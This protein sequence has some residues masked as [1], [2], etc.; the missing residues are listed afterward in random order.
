MHFADLPLLP[1]LHDSLT[2]LQL[3]T[4]TDVQEQ[5]L[6]LLLE[7]KS[8]VAIAET[9]SGKTLAY[10]LP[11]LDRLKRME[12]DGNPVTTGSE[13]R[14]LVIVP[15]R[16]LGEQ[17]AGVFKSMTHTTRL[18]VRT[19]LGGQKMK[20]NRESVAGAFEVLVATPGRLERIVE[21]GE[22]SLAAMRVLVLDEADQLLDLGF[23]PTVM[24]LVRGVPSQCQLALFS[25][26]MSPAVEELVGR[27]FHDA[28]RVTTAGRGKVVASLKTRH[29]PVPDGRRAEALRAVLAEPVEGSTMLFANTREQ[30]EALATWLREEGR[31]CVVH[32]GEMDP[33]ER[34]KNLRAFREGGVDLFLTTDMGS[35]GLD[36]DHV[37]RVIN[38]HLP[39]Q[40][41]NYLHR[42]GRTARAQ[43]PGLVVN[44]VT[45]RDAP[46]LAQLGDGTKAPT[47][48]P[49]PG[50]VVVTAQ[51]PLGREGAGRPLPQ[52]PP[53]HGASRPGARE[54]AP[55]SFQRPDDARTAR[56][57]DAP[58]SFQRPNDA[59]RS[60]QRPS[61][62]PRG[63]QRPSDAPRSFQ[64]TDDAPRSFQRPSDAPRSFQRTDDAPRSFQRADDAR[65]ARRDDTPRSFQR[66]DD[67]RPPRRDDAPRSFQRPDDA[68][69]SFQRPSDA[70]RGFQRPN[71]TRPERRDEAPRSFQRPD[72][73]PRSFQRPDDARPP[74]RDDAPRSFQR[75][76]DARPP[77]R[78]D[79]P[80]SFQRPGNGPR[81]PGRGGRGGNGRGQR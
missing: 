5:A 71:D 74:R 60:F 72:D 73:A 58:R 36:I 3:D 53:P 49:A 10:V 33:I 50:S 17:V 25:A 78:D 80:R 27:A 34:R 59:P 68:A 81:G 67:A 47:R 62:A 21:S 16:E 12:D 29:V 19:V 56:R 45:P 54:D 15:T 52:R 42:V 39:R 40:L 11:V 38:V 70:P 48:F 30:C 14:A 2:A 66:P 69:R 7:R 8:V 26:T 35:R 64:R 51:T 1:S 46:L 57:D 31:T 65:P 41:E 22:L 20:M 55:R 43:R 79:A 18:R 61:D 28:T 24:A 75:P 4:L 37:A 32:R 9:G 44:L 23:V 77:R 13:P 63:F 6:P 76:D